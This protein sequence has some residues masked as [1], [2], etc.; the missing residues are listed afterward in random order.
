MNGIA[1]MGGH[2]M[3][4]WQN[5]FFRRIVT[6]L[7]IIGCK[8]Q[9]SWRRGR[10]SCKGVFVIPVNSKS[11]EAKFFIGKKLRFNSFSYCFLSFPI[12]LLWIVTNMS[13]S[14]FMICF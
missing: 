1:A 2:K 11:Y 9:K 13:Q 8:C 14:H 3:V 4:A 6:Y 7:N 12:Y 10:D 5:L